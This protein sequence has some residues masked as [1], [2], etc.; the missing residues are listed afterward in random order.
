MKRVVAYVKRFIDIKCKNQTKSGP[1]TVEELTNAKYL[2][3]KLIQKQEFAVEFATLKANKPYAGKLSALS[4]IM[5][6][7]QLIRVGGRLQ[8]AHLSF[9][10]KYPILLPAKNHVTQVIIR[11]IHLDNKHSGVQATLY[12][13]RS[14]YWVVNGREVIK[15]ILHNCIA[16][17]RAKPKIPDHTM[18]NLP[19]NRV[20]N[21]GRIF[22]HT[23]VNFCEPFFIKEKRLRNRNKEKIY[24]AIFVCFATKAIHIEPV[25]DLTAESF[26]SA[27]NRCI[28]RK[29]RFQTCIPIMQ[30]ILL[31]QKIN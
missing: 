9:N 17:F 15:K 25:G 21:N 10:E 1:L 4:L 6:D 28:K 20:T 5:C 31:V 14:K 26:I 30:T 29:G 16:C 24:V 11:D 23:G 3:I 7:R 12:A 18:G 19:K 22:T 8:N 27:L 2:I 13:L